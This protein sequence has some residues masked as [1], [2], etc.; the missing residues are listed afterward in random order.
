MQQSQIVVPKDAAGI[1]QVRSLTTLGYD[2][3]PIGLAE[4]VFEKVRAPL[5]N[6]SL[7]EG[8][9]FEIVQ[10]RLG[11]GRTHHCMHLI[12]AAQRSL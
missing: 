9:G 12:G 8:R 5:A 2:D 1:T 10:G 11:P 7:G 3:T 4:I 6:I